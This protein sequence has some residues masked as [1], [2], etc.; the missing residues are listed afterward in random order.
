MSCTSVNLQNKKSL[1]TV[2]RDL[3]N[4]HMRQTGQMRR[5]MYAT[6]L[7]SLYHCRSFTG[8]PLTC[9]FSKRDFLV[10]FTLSDMTRC[11]SVRL[12]P[13]LKMAL[14]EDSNPTSNFLFDTDEYPTA[15]SGEQEK[16]ED[17]V[18]DL[19][20]EY[21]GPCLV[22]DTSEPEQQLPLKSELENVKLLR[23]KHVKYLQNGLKYLK[24]S[25][26]SLDASRPWLCYWILHGLCL[27]GEEVDAEV[28]AQI[29]GFLARCQSPSGGFCG[30]P[31]QYPHVGSTYAAVMALCCLG[32]EEA[33]KV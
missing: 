9:H 28:S 14:V 6:V 17:S 30:G 10:G 7:Y 4:M 2:H 1:C 27:L 24:T 20:K 25:F 22:H 11:L 8:Y 23:C 31:G 29:T 26:E 5:Y 12:I 3:H 16:V 33:Y 19:F 13:H 18:L 15:S 21:C 32:T